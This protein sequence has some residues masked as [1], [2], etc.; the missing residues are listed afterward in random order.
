[1]VQVHSFA[2]RCLFLPA[3]GSSA[4]ADDQLAEGGR[5]GLWAHCAGPLFLSVPQCCDDR[6]LVAS[7]EI[8]RH[9]SSSSFWLFGGKIDL[10]KKKKKTSCKIHMQALPF[11]KIH[12]SGSRFLELNVSCL[13]A[14]DHRRITRR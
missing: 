9:E 11:E 2:C 14:C 3:G 1:M 5:P 4:V 8:G 13:S 10:K 6:G 7:F 12:S